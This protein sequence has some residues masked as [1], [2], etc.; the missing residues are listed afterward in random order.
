MK[1]LQPN[2]D[3]SCAPITIRLARVSDVPELLHL[4]RAYY[5]FDGIRFQ[6]SV[7]DAALRK[8]PRN[9]SLGRIWIMRDGVKPAGYIMLTFNYDLEFGGL[10]GIVTDL[11]IESEYRSRGLGRGALEL[12]YDYCRSAGIRTVELQVE[13]HN[14]TAQA[15]YRKLGFRTL[16]RIVMSRDVRQR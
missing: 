12:V 3:S 13:E 2:I 7:I 14:K 11:F 1:H 8:L 5:K 16:T 6:K 15:F 9:R 10:E 4:I